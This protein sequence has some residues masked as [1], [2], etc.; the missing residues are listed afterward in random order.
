MK[1]SQNE[2]EMSKGGIQRRTPACNISDDAQRAQNVS[3]DGVPVG[4]AFLCQWFNGCLLGISGNTA[5]W[6]KVDL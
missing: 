1:W 3:S 4:L 6:G 2:G 5:H